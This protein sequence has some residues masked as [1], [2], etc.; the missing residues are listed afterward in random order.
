LERWQAQLGK[1][2]IAVG[3]TS[4]RT[5]ESLYW[6]GIKLMKEE[7][8]HPPT[9]SQWEC[10]ALQHEIA[11]LSE[12]IETLIAWMKR[13]KYENFVTQTSLLVAPGYTCRVVD[14][15]LTNFHQPRSTLLLLIAALVGDDWRKIYRHALDNEYRFL[16]YGDG[17]LLWRNHQ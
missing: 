14:G 7:H 5:L 13:N 12:V 11:P 8:T 2:L 9:L 15:L 16:S 3:T 10:Y 1:P 17:S 6:L 4:L